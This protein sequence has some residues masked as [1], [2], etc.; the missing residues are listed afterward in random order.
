[1]NNSINIEGIG[2]KK[3]FIDI[4]EKLCMKNLIDDNER[5]KLVSIINKDNSLNEKRS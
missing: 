4:A 5:I 2:Y 1:M 3:I